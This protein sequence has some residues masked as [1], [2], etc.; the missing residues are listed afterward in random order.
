LADLRLRTLNPVLKQ[1][2]ASLPVPNA[3]TS[4]LPAG[5]RA[6]SVSST[7]STSTARRSS[8]V[9]KPPPSP[10]APRNPGK[11]NGRGKRA[12]S[13]A[14][15]I[16]EEDSDESG[17]EETSSTGA[18][19]RKASSSSGK[20]NGTPRK[21][22]ST[23][24][25]VVKPK[26]RKPPVSGINSIPKLFDLFPLH[27]S[28]SGFEISQL[29]EPNVAPRAVFVFGTGDM[30]QFGLGTDVLDEIKRPRRH[31]TF[32]EKIEQGEKGWSGGAADIIC[33]GMHSL[34]VDGEGKVWSWGYVR[35][36]FFLLPSHPLPSVHL[37]PHLP[38]SLFSF[39]TH[40]S[41]YSINDNAALGR[42][43]SK[44]DVEAE[45][46]E[47]NPFPVENLTVSATEPFKAVRVSAGDSVSLAVSDHGDVRA[48]GSFRVRFPVSVFHL[49]HQQ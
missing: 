14:S 10:A 5:A 35:F 48:W 21:K 7:T 37:G 3:D 39:L 41:L 23:E 15:D 49:L 31:A 24:A 43:T 16:S 1:Q 42:V 47:S 4:L 27:S 8:R 2:H 11:A 18:K 25:R 46:L 20:A 45:E 12:A 40:A 19:K 34:A 22:T 28:F 33:G 13:V 44:P 29:P 30:G 38:L 32:K 17:E 26:P 9:S 6:S 36:L